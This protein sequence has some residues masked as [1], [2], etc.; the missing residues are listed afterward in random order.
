MGDGWGT[1]LREGTGLQTLSLPWRWDGDKGTACACIS[2]ASRAALG[3]G[4]IPANP[5]RTHTLAPASPHP[6]PAPPAK[7]STGSLGEDRRKII[8]EKWPVSG[9][10]LRVNTWGAA[11]ITPGAIRWHL[12]A[13]R[14][15]RAGRAARTAGSQP[16][17]R[18][19]GWEPGLPPPPSL[20]FQWFLL[21]SIAR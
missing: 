4:Q 14:E 8:W 11:R 1:I 15:I 5:G 16:R 10:I 9:L 13:S 6:E 18:A 12:A 3:S 21:L 2:R 17:D 7:S 20:H 19:L